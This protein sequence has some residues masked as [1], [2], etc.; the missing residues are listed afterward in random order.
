MLAHFNAVF[1]G[2][3]KLFADGMYVCM[4]VRSY[5][6]LSVKTLLNRFA[7]LPTYLPT[8]LHTGDPDVKNGANLLDRLIKDIVTE[9]ELF[10]V[11]KFIPLLKVCL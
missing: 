8:Y 11:E 6:R 4:Y 10:D 9:S 3:C 1:E 7:H 5:V 2:L